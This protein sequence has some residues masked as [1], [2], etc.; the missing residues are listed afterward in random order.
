MILAGGFYEMNVFS[1]ILYVFLIIIV[2]VSCLVFLL[3]WFLVMGYSSFQLVRSIQIGGEKY[4]EKWAHDNGLEVLHSERRWFGSPWW[5][6]TNFAAQKI[7]HIA[8]GDPNDDDRVRLAW[9]RCGDWFW[10]MRVEKVDVRWDGPWQ[11]FSKLDPKVK[12]THDNPL[13]DRWVDNEV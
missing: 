2:F 3:A 6:S 9:I 11:S 7:Y 13:T 8:L 12:T 10:G 4:I 1:N 5:I